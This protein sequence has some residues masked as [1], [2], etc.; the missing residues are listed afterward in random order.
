MHPYVPVCVTCGALVAHRHF[1][2]PPSCKTPQYRRIF[3]L[4]SVSLWIDRYD[5]VFDGLGLAG[6]KDR[7]NAF[8]NWPN[9]L[10]L[11]ISYYFLFFLPWVGCVGMGSSG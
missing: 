10:F 3:V 6:F 9:Q 4:L 7:V 1:L 5:P 11:F 8:F 2:M